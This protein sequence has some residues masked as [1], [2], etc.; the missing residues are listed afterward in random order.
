MTWTHCLQWP[1]LPSYA[2]VHTLF[3]AAVVCWRQ[4]ARLGRSSAAF[5]GVHISSL[6]LLAILACIV[7]RSPEC[8]NCLVCSQLAPVP[9]TARGLSKPTLSFLVSA[10]Q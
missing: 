9:G 8:V 3:V 5:L 2:T 7:L 6:L 1:A 4:A 10:T